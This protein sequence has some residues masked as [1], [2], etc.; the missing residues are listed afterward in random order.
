MCRDLLT[1]RGLEKFGRVVSPFVLPEANSAMEGRMLPWIFGSLSGV[2]FPLWRG[3][4]V[5]Q[6]T[7]DVD[8]DATTIAIESVAGLPTSGLVQ[9]GDEQFSYAAVDVVLNTLGT[10]GTLSAA[11]PPGHGGLGHGRARHP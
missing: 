7:A 1:V 3:G 2:A 5:L 8:I 4:V 11:R 9:L 6:L 10:S